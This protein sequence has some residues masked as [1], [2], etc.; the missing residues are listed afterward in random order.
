MSSTS[1]RSSGGEIVLETIL[2]WLTPEAI[3]QIGIVITGIL[4]IWV[5]R[6]SIE[7]KKVRTEL[8]ETKIELDEIKT[9]R[10]KDRGVIKAATQYIGDQAVRIAVL[11]GLLRQHAPHVEIPPDLAPPREL[12]AEE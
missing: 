7:L 3:Q 5:G 6:Q 4:T 1:T 12:R 9:E 11:T 10:V 2:K 8:D